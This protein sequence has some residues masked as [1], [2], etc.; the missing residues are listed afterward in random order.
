MEEKGKIIIG[1]LVGMIAGGGLIIGLDHISSPTEG[2]I[3]IEEEGVPG[4]T[5][6]YN[7]AAADQI[8]VEDPK[9]PGDY[10][11]LSEYLKRDFE[12][13]YERNLERAKIKLA[14]SQAEGK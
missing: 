14:V 11:P 13:K 10:L 3:S 7:Y 6:V 1:G 2:A 9:W 5:K 12:N 8:L 4:I